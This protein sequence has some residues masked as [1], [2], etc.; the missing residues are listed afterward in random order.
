M[1]SCTNHSA[2][3]HLL[4]RLLFVM[5]IWQSPAQA[6]IISPGKLSHAHG[7]LSGITQCTACHQLGKKGI[8]ND[9]CLSCHEPLRASLS[10]QMGLHFNFIS[11][12]C[13][14]CHKEH[15][16]PEFKPVRFDTTSFDHLK[17]G[18]DLIGGHRKAFC[19]SCHRPSH[20]FNPTVRRFKQ[21]HG[22][23]TSTFLGLGARCV[24]CHQNDSPH[25]DQF[26]ELSCTDCHN[27]VD[28]KKAPKF[29]HKTT[30]FPLLGKHR[31]IACQKC[32]QPT[33]DVDGTVFVRFGSLG[34]TQCASCH[35]DAHRGTMG[36]SCANC[37]QEKG[38]HF[39]NQANFKRQF[40]HSATR[41]DLEGAHAQI[42][43]ASCHQTPATGQSGIHITFKPETIGRT[44]PSPLVRDCQSCHVDFHHGDFG[45]LP[46]GPL[47]SNC[48]EQTGWSPT[49]FDLDRHN[50]ETNFEL[51]GAHLAT[52]CIAC[53]G[54]NNRPSLRFHFAT[55]ACISCHEDTSPHG[56]Q[57]AEPAGP[58]D[59]QTCHSTN[60]WKMSITFDH[61]RTK[62]PLNGAHARTACS[63][64][65][66]SGISKQMDKTIRYAGLSTRCADC[67]HDQNPHQEQFAGLA[68]SSCHDTESFNI[69][70]MDHNRT[71]FP[72]DGAHQKVACLSCHHSV[73][74][75]DGSSFIRYKPLG[76]AC[77][78]CHSK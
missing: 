70:S 53:H 71:R 35:K 51:T 42:K 24:G 9:K 75:V 32:H 77:I 73:T 45:K 31:D 41:F 22:V 59:C 55:I 69:K 65:H 47:C 37:H 16:G 61:S 3:Y 1:T 64:C 26:T 5:V 33:T 63:G 18:F 74:A 76:T 15:F 6:Q 49:L 36:S 58:R 11:Q 25:R 48:H 46:D 44:F 30:R 19:T 10:D 40:D 8:Q 13:A 20:I 7:D 38:W 39:L 67:H 60:T 17:T 50:R 12:N 29:D 2:T 52:P 21:Q 28:W 72:L 34:S 54:S 66:V 14:E 68:C 62:F 27:E 57:F 78:D 4:F 43:C 23:L 56:N